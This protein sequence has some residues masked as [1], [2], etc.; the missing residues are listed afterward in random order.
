MKLIKVLF[1]E[2]G[3]MPKQALKAVLFLLLDPVIYA[4]LRLKGLPGVLRKEFGL[5]S[6]GRLSSVLVRSQSWHGRFSLRPNNFHA[7]PFMRRK[8]ILEE[9]DFFFFPFGSFKK[10]ALP[11]ESEGSKLSPR[12]A[13]LWLCCKGLWEGF[14]YMPRSSRQPHPATP[15]AALDLGSQRFSLGH[16]GLS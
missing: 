14:L 12:L 3:L 5:F 10:S 9:N 11:K 15:Q 1:C 2:M 16:V 8:S 6:K 4:L 7:Y 13:N